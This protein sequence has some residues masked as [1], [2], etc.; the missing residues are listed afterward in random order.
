MLKAIDVGL[1]IPIFY[2]VG[3]LPSHAVDGVR[4]CVYRILVD[5][6]VDVS[7]SSHVVIASSKNAI[8]GLVERQ[9]AVTGYAEY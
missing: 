8:D 3:V 9:V 6:W 2:G 7:H 5:E 4:D 1:G